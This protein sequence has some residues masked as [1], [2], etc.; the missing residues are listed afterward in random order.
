MLRQADLYELVE[1]WVVIF[2]KYLGDA[3]HRSKDLSRIQV[4]SVSGDF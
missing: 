2:G 1:E 3:S 4:V